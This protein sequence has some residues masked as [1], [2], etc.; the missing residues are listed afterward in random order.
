MKWVNHFERYRIIE[1][2]EESSKKAEAEIA[3][4]GSSKRKG[5]ELEQEESAKKQKVDEAQETAKMKEHIRVVPGEEEVA[6]DAIPLAIKP[7]SIMYKVF[8]QLLKSFD[9]E[10]LETLWRLVKA[11]HGY[12]RPEEGYERVLWGDL[13]TMFEPHVEDAVW[14]NLQGNRVLIWKLFDSCRGR[15]VGIKR[16]LDDLRVT[17][18]KFRLQSIGLEAIRFMWSTFIEEAKCAHSYAVER[19]SL[20]NCYNHEYAKI[21]K[22]QVIIGM[23]CVSLLKLSQN[24]SQDSM[25]V[26]GTHPPAKKF[27]IHS[28]GINKDQLYGL[29]SDAL[30]DTLPPLLK[31]SITSSISQSITEELPHVEAQVQKNL[32]DQ[33]HTLLLKPMY[34]EFNA[35]NKLESQRFAAEVFKKANAEGEKWEKNNPTKENDA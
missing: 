6:I 25:K 26:F 23:I 20:T 31:D 15:I 9:R 34:K 28:S 5:T 21:G 17:D 14:R 27:K 35:F 12:T 8:S 16:L 22:L 7:P 11:K 29:L 3:H 18:V 1:L 4:E 10:D 24:K 32:H 30:K 19:V 2:V 13:K 33:L